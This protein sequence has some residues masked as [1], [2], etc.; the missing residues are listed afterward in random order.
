MDLNMVQTWFQQGLLNRDQLVLPVGGTRWVRLGE[1]VDLTRWQAPRGSAMA[2]RG[3]GRLPE[4]PEVEPGA[5]PWRLVV[6]AALFFGLAALAFLAAFAPDRVRPELDGTP[7]ARLGLGLVALGLLLVRGWNLGRRVA[8]VVGLLAVAAAFPLAGLFV[9]RGMRGE[10]LLA[11]ASSAL[12]AFGLVVLLAPRLSWLASTAAL[13]LVASGAAGLV[14]FVPTPA[15]AA[16]SEVGAWAA[17]DRRI[18][19]PEAGLELPLPPGWVVLKAGN[20]LV[21]APPAARVTLG[22]PR[23]SA[24][25][26]LLFEPAPPRVRMLEHYLDEVIAR[27]RAAVAEH[28]EGWRR[29][30]RLG[31]LASRRASTRHGGPA[32]WFLERIVV[33]QDGDHYVA[34]VVTVPEAGGG[35]ALEEVDALEAAISLSGV[36]GRRLLAAVE[37]ANLELPH[38]SVHAIE[39]LVEVGGPASPAELFRRAGALSARGLATL[40]DSEARELQ[41]LLVV[42]LGGLSSAERAQLTDYLRRVGAGLPTRA[43]EDERMRLAMKEAVLRLVDVQRK[44]LGALNERAI[45]GALEE[46]ATRP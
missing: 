25:A 21:E 38:L 43:D 37:A 31:A 27:R 5:E 3:A 18:S 1:A 9:A 6:A 40:G 34:L 35:R 30:G 41:G 24:F 44:R 20:P 17:A 12:V 22:Q 16:A 4:S 36:R 28:E 13:L 14:R 26:L 15:S 39:R 32:G 46:P 33:A 11:L 7:W 23:V 45:S 29:D 19:D 2:A 8:R 42:A 10:A